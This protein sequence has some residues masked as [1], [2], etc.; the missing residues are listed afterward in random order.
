MGKNNKLKIRQESSEMKEHFKMYKA[1]KLWLYA[2]IATFA[3]AAGLSFASTDAHAATANDTAAPTTAVTS[4]A[5]STATISKTEETHPTVIDDNNVGA[6]PTDPGTETVTATDPALIKGSM[7]GSTTSAAEN[8]ATTGLGA[9]SAADSSVAKANEDTN[10]TADEYGQV[11]LVS[12]GEVSTNPAANDQLDQT[13]VATTTTTQDKIGDQTVTSDIYNDQGAISSDVNNSTDRATTIYT[14]GQNTGIS[15][16]TVGSNQHGVSIGVPANL[17]NVQVGTFK[18][19][20]KTS[21][22]LTLKNEA[23]NEFVQI[24]D[25]QT[26]QAYAI[27]DEIKNKAVIYSNFNGDGL[28]SVTSLVTKAIDGVSTGLQ[29]LGGTLISG[30]NGVVGAVNTA[31]DVASGPG[32]LIPGVGTA[33]SAVQD[34]LDE[35]Q[36]DLQAAVDNINNLEDF[37]SNLMDG[38]V[39]QAALVDATYDPATGV[40]TALSSDSVASA[41]GNM[42]NSYITGWFSGVIDSVQKVLGLSTTNA[43]GTEDPTNPWNTLT[44]AIS[45]A[46]SGIPLLGNIVSLV[47]TGIAGIATSL[48][49]SIADGINSAQTSVTNFVSNGI[50]D[51]VQ[52]AIDGGLGVSQTAAVPLTWTDPDLSKGGAGTF[53]AETFKTNSALYD[54]SVDSDTT[55]AYQ[56]VDK[57]QLGDLIATA[58]AKGTDTKAAQTVFDN[59][60]ASQED[61]DDAIRALGGNV[62]VSS[63]TAV[64]TAVLNPIT[65]T[66][67]QTAQEALDAKAATA[68]TIT[69]ASGSD[70][71]LTVTLGAGDLV[72]TD[73]P[74]PNADGSTKQNYTLS[75]AGQQKLNDAATA[76]GYTV[77]NI[78]KLSSTVTIPAASKISYNVQPVDEAG[79]ALGTAVAGSGA[80]GTAISTSGLPASFTDANGKAWNLPKNLSSYLVPATNGA[81]VNVLYTD[82]DPST[83]TGTNT[84]SEVSY[85]VIIQD[86]NGHRLAYSGTTPL[87]GLPGAPITFGD[88]SYEHDGK[89]W[90][91]PG[92]EISIPD[93]GGDVVI[94][95]INNDQPDT[96]GNNSNNNS[97]EDEPG[98]TT[99]VVVPGQDGEDG[100]EVQVIKNEMVQPHLS[101]QTVQ[102]QPSLLAIQI[103]TKTQLAAHLL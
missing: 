101:S 64:A 92:T 102:R 19:V 99:I 24:T 22:G 48:S 43:D 70:A 72:P 38:G 37:G 57:T 3:L 18:V 32:S 27:G 67:G 5:T 53:T 61:V 103:I 9:Q 23:T 86:E 31:L 79:N 49:G 16:S 45:S 11:S 52:T 76:K 80:A 2:G 73:T 95:Y 10:R 96:T 36:D 56:N 65:G 63:T 25:P 58:N 51:A 93:I 6:H 69:P 94:T 98:K 71:S 60:N 15:L 97:G 21:V 82:V 50:T 78:D 87:T 90:S 28:Q 44:A 81:T 91:K 35:Y 66:A 42:V 62:T 39:T 68:I 47:T 1:G 41:I 4:A 29:D 75:A 12:G 77:T 8:S 20:D 74:T 59:A 85:R 14:T 84:G 33:I 89:T 54:K 88:V 34:A 55:I 30:I 46:T 7:F 100:Q 13:I 83:G 40:I 17:E 26:A